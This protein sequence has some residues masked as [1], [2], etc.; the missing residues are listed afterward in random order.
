[1]AENFPFITVILPIRNE[2]KILQK[3]LH[4]IFL[5]TYPQECMEILISDGMSFDHTREIIEEFQK[6][7]TNIYLIDNPGLIVPTGLNLA[8]LHAKGEII[9][10]IDGHTVLDPDYILNC[11]DAL[12]R[13]GADNVG[14]KMHAV[15]DTFVGKAIALA[16]ST[17]FGVGGARF[18]YSNQEEW[19]DTV[20]MGAWPMRVFYQIG[21]F[22]EE[23]VR[24]QDDEFNYRLREM[25]GKI[26]L[27]PKIKSK[28]TT[29]STLKSLWKQYFQ[30]GF[31]K[32]RVLQKHPKQMRPRQFIP[33]VFTFML[34]I[35]TLLSFFIKQGWFAF[36]SIAGLYIAANFSASFITAR[37]NHL[38]FIPVLMI[39]FAI[40]HLSYGFGFLIG[41]Y[42]FRN[43]WNDKIGKSVEYQ[44]P[45]VAGS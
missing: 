21:L 3:T 29:R 30:Y 38:K 6:T 28:Y 45:H 16:T 18:H 19:V 44:L 5:Q 24:D 27:S 40:L 39:T 20:Y 12:T 43:R 8:L 23:L 10:R 1:M 31:W 13:T 32:I 37:W 25:G 2:E 9:V 34:I 7:H 4:S 22:D 35:S 14:G 11:V 17:P 41:L 26:L 33:P 42:A 36:A 15:G